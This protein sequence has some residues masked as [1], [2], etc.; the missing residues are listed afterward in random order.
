[1]GGK[2]RQIEISIRNPNPLFKKW[3]TEWAN[4]AEGLGRDNQAVA[5]RRALFSLDKYPLPLKTGYECIILDGFGKSICEML[6][7]KLDKHRKHAAEDK[8]IQEAQRIKSKETPLVISPAKPK[9]PPKQMSLE[10][11]PLNQSFSQPSTSA[12]GGKRIRKIKS[13]QNLPSS[14]SLAAAQDHIT[15]LTSELPQQSVTGGDKASSSSSVGDKITE[16]VIM[17]PG[18]F[19]VILLVDSSETQG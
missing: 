4:H 2:H 13:A 7:K 1:M 11:E 14:S 9:L 18:T 5:F 10:D 12:A 6:D 3:L 17:I 19:Q 15:G 16:E 8:L